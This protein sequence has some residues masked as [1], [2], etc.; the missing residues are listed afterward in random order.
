MIKKF[1]YIFNSVSHLIFPEKCIHCQIELIDKE[2][3]ICNTCISGVS[4]TFF[5]NYAEHTKMDKLFWGRVPI[6]KTYALYNFEKDT[7]VQSILHALKYKNN[8]QIGR[9]FGKKI[10]EKIIQ[11]EGFKDLNALIPVPMHPK[12]KFLRGYNQAEMLAQGISEITNIPIQ[13]SNVKK[14]IHTE[15]QTQKSLWERWTTSENI[16][17]Y[18]PNNDSLRHIALVDDVLTTGAT[19]ERLAK[20]ILDNN[21]DLKISLITLAITK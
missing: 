13:T 1:S 11:L 5:E 17:S 12:K 14:R 20:T 15:S 19:M 3:N 8:P 16:F 18:A 21:P 2:W 6:H 9:K 10:G 7:V 4:Y